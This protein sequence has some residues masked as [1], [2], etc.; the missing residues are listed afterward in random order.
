MPQK[1][2][3]FSL[4]PRLIEMI[5]AVQLQRQDPSRSDTVR[6]LLLRAL[7]D[8][9]YLKRQQLNALMFGVHNVEKEMSVTS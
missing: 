2:V 5:D 4:P 3:T 7:A 6:L 8:L 1:G 9:G